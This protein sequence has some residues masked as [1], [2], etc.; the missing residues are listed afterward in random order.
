MWS[1]ILSSL[2][3]K[4]SSGAL[5]RPRTF[6]KVV[7]LLFVDLAHVINVIDYYQ[8]AITHKSSWT[9]LH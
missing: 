9:R 2:L 8:Y 4:H 3:C 5:V 1:D 7:I 6:N